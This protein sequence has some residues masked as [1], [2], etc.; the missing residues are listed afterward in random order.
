VSAVKAKPKS[1]NTGFI[2]ALAAVV[3]AGAGFMWWKS[4]QKP[5]EAQ[6][7]LPSV[8]DE[9]L[10]AKARGYTIGVPTAPVE[11]IEFAD[12]ECP[13]CGNF[14]ALTEPQVRKELVDKGLIR[15]TFYDFPLVNAHPNTITASMAAACADDQGK[16][17]D[18]H[19]KI[20]ENQFE[21]SAQS[22]QNPR[23]VISVYAQRLNIDMPKWNACMDAGTHRERIQA[24]YALGLVKKVPS[25]PTFFV[26]GTM[27]DTRS[28]SYDELKTAIDA[29]AA[30]VA[31]PA[32]APAP[33][34]S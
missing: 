1:S 13:A 6:L 14:A 31:P 34:K 26:N 18:L 22:T 20:F 4:Q 32:P 19:D 28:N 33:A 9:A 21:W 23:G 11:L 30:A 3:V 8:A 12:F 16:F 25:T 27:V 15:Y 24:N 29:A 2:A 5:A 17:W 10:A 7:T